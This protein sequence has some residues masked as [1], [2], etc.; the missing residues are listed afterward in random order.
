MREIAEYKT[1][2]AL[3]DDIAVRALQAS[4]LKG[5]SKESIRKKIGIFLIPE[6]RA[7][8]HGRLIGAQD[9]IRCG[10]TVDLKDVKDKM[11]LL[12]YELY[13]RLNNYVSIN[14][15]A[16]VIECRDKAFTARAQPKQ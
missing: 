7:K 11:W 4:M 1:A 6:K 16:K 5:L 13:V 14:N 12:L 15:N 10:L 2:L 8:V 3:S 9:A